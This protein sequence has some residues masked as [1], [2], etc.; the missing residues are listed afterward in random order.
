MAATEPTTVDVAVR[1]DGFSPFAPIVLLVAVV[2]AGPALWACFVEGRL[3]VADALLR[4]L[5]TW[6]ASAFGICLLVALVGPDRRAPAP[7]AEP[8]PGSAP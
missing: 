7:D 6:G 5:I 1:G 4:L 3:P 2:L 8:D